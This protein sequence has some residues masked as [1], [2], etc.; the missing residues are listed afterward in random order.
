MAAKPIVNAV[1]KKLPVRDG[2][3]VSPLFR[4]PRTLQRGKGRRRGS[5]QM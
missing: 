1:D 4:Q 2:I 3:D 5:N